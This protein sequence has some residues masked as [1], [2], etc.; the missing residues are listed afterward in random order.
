[1][2]VLHSRLKAM[3]LADGLHGTVIPRMHPFDN[4]M[5]CLDLLA[6]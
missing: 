5:H 1:M 2:P 4:N 3:G 6:Q